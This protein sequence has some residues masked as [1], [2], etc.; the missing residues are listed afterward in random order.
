MEINK[1]KLFWLDILFFLILLALGAYFFYKSSP[2]ANTPKDD[3]S[4]TVTSTSSEVSTDL[5]DGVTVEDLGDG[6]R[7]VKN[8]KEGYQVE[9]K[10]NYVIE[11][12][13]DSNLAVSSYPDNN[14]I[15]KDLFDYRVVLST[16]I[17]NLD[18]INLD[19]KNTCKENLD[20]KSYSIDSVVKNSITWKKI[21]YVGDYVGS[22]WPEFV[23]EKNG[24]IFSL[25][26]QYANDYF[27]NE[28]LNNFSF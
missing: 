27:I 25:Y 23:T 5:P 12:T 19:I 7:L 4:T 22:G 8:E 15:K 10:N 16:K 3:N 14:N 17:G 2:I 28:T 6:N 20:C 24:K 11:K 1:K 21:M 18:N 13:P 26:F 9:V